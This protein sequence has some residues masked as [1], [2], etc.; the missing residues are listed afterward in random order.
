VLTYFSELYGNPSSMHTS[1][2]VGIKIREARETGCRLLGAVPTSHFYQCGTESDNNGI[3]SALAPIRIVEY[4]TVGG[5]IQP[6]KRSAPLANR[7]IV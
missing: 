2:E 7:A 3:R 1:G 4:V 6:S 5:S